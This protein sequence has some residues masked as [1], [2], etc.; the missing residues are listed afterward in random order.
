MGFF[1]PLALLF[2]LLAVPI[3]ALYLLRLRR[4][5]RRVSSTFLWRQV[6]RDM[7]ANTP[8]QRLRPNVLLLLQLLALAALVFTLARPYLMR[9]S[10][11]QGDLIIV[12]DTSAS[13]Q[14]ADLQPSR[15]ARA[16]EEALGL[17]EQLPPG[18]VA[19]LILMGDVPGVPVA[20]SGDKETLRRAIRDARPGVGGA[21]LGAALSLAASLV[22][23]Q[24]PVQVVLLSD[25]SFGGT[26]PVGALPFQLRYVP[27]GTSAGNLALAAFSTRHTERGVEALARVA[28]HG[29][30]AQPTTLHLYAD[31]RLY[32]VRSLEV[33]AG[34]DQVVR[35]VGLP[36]V[37]LLEARLVPGD[38]FPL[39]D[40]AWALS[41]P[42]SQGRALLVTQGN[43]F[44]EK[45]LSLLPG[46]EV[47][48]A[49][50]DTYS[51]QGEG[52]P[53]ASSG[54]RLWVFDG[55]LP[56][57]LPQGAVLV[58][59][60]PAGGAPWLKDNFQP[61]GSL[62]PGQ[63]ELL[64]H[65]DLSSVHILEAVPLAPPP[66]ARVLLDSSQG[67]LIA[68]WEEPRRRVAVL[69]FDLHDS[70]L[71]LQPAF[72]ILMQALVG[73]LVPG[74]GQGLTVQPGDTVE[75]PLPPEAEAAWVETPSGR[76]EQIAPPL[77]PRPLA[78]EEVGPYRIVQQMGDGQATTYF[79]A[80]L[81]RPEE[82]DLAP[83]ELPP[84]ETRPGAGRSCGRIPW[85]L[86]PWVALA[87]LAILGLEWW[88][89]STGGL[90]R[91]KSR[92]GPAPGVRQAGTGGH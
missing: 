24:R 12:M 69:S 53:Q 18:N 64:S 37:P 32:D 15:F 31:G 92:T 63:D 90:Y 28:N 61:V 27:I 70:D 8:W 41:G 25:G 2:G 45:A 6:V 79:V 54:Q 72:P 47:T 44:L 13:M 56:A 10:P 50:P 46:L 71:P 26:Q 66:T 85:E 38:A 52:A 91:R 16:Q 23:G 88:V 14:A 4:R 5:E 67:P 39:D 22:Q 19:T 51:P 36:Q 43:R 83:R 48:L 86:A 30:Q 55:F 33:P 7:E 60:P 62:E 82:S 11:V 1:A 29:P 34:G 77:P 49:S 42:S 68:V 59:G 87:A 40:R 76:R 20:Q 84:L 35:W 89:Y 65:A 75:V 9:E 80:N 81:F 3:I 21:D 74:L 57:E 58:V 78:V 17:V 73:W